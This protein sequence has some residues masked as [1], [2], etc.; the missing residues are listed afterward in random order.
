MSLSITNVTYEIS[1]RKGDSE[2]HYSTSSHYFAKY[3]N[4]HSQSSFRHRRSFLH[5]PISS[6]TKEIHAF[7]AEVAITIPPA[8]NKIPNI[9]NV[10]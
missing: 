8:R 1:F 4:Q 2:I 6:N 10:M 3:D 7:I 9:M 5:K